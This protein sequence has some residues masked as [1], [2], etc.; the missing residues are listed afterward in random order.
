M[1]ITGTLLE[2]L[3]E[4]YSKNGTAAAAIAGWQAHA[5]AGAKTRLRHAWRDFT[6]TKAP[7]SRDAQE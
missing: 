5:S 3:S 1:A 4:E 6:K 2:E 7:W